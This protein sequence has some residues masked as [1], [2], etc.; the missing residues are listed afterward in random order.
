[1]AKAYVNLHSI[2]YLLIL[3][4]GTMKKQ[5]TM[6]FTFHNVSINS[7]DG[8]VYS[9]G[10][11]KFTFHN[12]SINSEGEKDTTMFL[13]KFTFHNVSINSSNKI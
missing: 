5:K 12:V 7:G 1:M 3:M 10:S 2:M 8:S 9:L 6:I 4:I 13:K 11:K